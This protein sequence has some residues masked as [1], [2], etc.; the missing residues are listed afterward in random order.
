M[1]RN[2][3]IQKIKVYNIKDPEGMKKFKEI[4]SKSGFLPEVF[5]DKTKNVN[6]TSKRFIKRLGFFIAKCFRKVRINGRYKNKALE[7]LLNRRR[8]LRSKKNENSIE[9]LE[10]VNKILSEMC[11]GKG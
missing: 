5:Q 3:N 10:N 8:I 11:L 9:E 7:E 2:K 1:G 6:T 4:T